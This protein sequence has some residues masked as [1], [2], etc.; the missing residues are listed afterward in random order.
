MF[1]SIRI[2]AVFKCYGQPGCVVVVRTR[3]LLLPYSPLCVCVRPCVCVRENWCELSCVVRYVGVWLCV[4][5]L[6]LGFARV[7]EIGFASCVMCPT[8]LKLMDS[9]LY[10]FCTATVLCV[11]VFVLDRR[12]VLNDG[13]EYCIGDDVGSFFELL[14]WFV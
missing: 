11:V 4:S 14:S 6:F 12:T 8:D 2:C 10:E 13:L 1:P 7:C 3:H 5:S 9:W